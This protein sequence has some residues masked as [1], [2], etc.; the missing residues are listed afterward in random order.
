MPASSQAVERVLENYAQATRA[1]LEFAGR[2]GLV[3]SVSVREADEVMITADLHGHRRNFERLTKIAALES[4]P[5]RHMV[6]QEVCH[7]GP[8]YPK[9]G[10]CMSHLMIEDVA[11]L[12]ARFTDRF[13]FILSNHELGE[14]TDYPI[15]KGG[16]MLNVMFY[17]GLQELYGEEYTQRVRKAMVEFLWSCPVAV[18]LPD[19]VFVSHS[20]PERV[21][22]R[23]F[24][25]KVLDAPM[26]DGEMTHREAIFSIV[27]G[28]D[29]RAENAAAFAKA[30]DARI[31]V[32]G[33]EP[34]REGFAAPNE[35]QIILDC[36]RERFSYLMLP[37]AETLTHAE[38]CERVR[39]VG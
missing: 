10:G 16:Q 2:K 38:L 3:A 21:D 34:C 22:V 15:T 35:H 6:M 31:L 23:G 11:A 25:P 12:K 4:F 17:M 29:F 8:R 26:G 13:H 1:N 36:H 27:W 30:V 39:V 28:R 33:H 20:L 18:R 19:D 24:D 32:H 7:G 9:G 5:R 37:T 14:M